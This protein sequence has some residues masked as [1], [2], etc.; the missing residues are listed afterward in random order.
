MPAAGKSSARKPTPAQKPSGAAAAKA[1]GAGV[2]A[3]AAAKGTSGAA[4]T[5]AGAA[6]AAG[7]AAGDGSSL[8]FKDLV[9]QLQAVQASVLALPAVVLKDPAV[10]SA[11]ASLQAFSS[12]LQRAE[13]Q[14]VKSIESVPVVKQLQS[15]LAVLAK[16]LEPYKQAAAA[17]LN[18]ANLVKQLPAP[19]QTVEKEVEKLAA[20]VSELIHIISHDGDKDLFNGYPF[21]K[22]ALALWFASVFAYSS[23]AYKDD[24]TPYRAG[25]YDPKAAERFYAKRWALKWARSAQLISVL[26][27]WSIGV[28]RDKYEY[29]GIGGK[30]NKWEENMPMRAKQILNICTRLGTTAI[31]IG[32][33]LS[34]R[35]D[36]LP[37][38]YVKELSEL[39]DRV[40]PFPTQ[41]A[42]AIIEEEL[43]ASG[44]GSIKSVFRKISQDPVAAASIGQVFKAEL[45]DGTEV[46]VKVQRPGVIQDIALDL[47]I[48]RLVAPLYK[49][50]FK[51]NSD[52]VGLVDEWGRGFVDELDYQREAVNGKRF[53]AAMQARGLD[54]VTTSEVVDDL[55]SD[56]I[57]VTKWVDG[58]RLSKSTEDDVGRLCGVALNAY[59]T[60]L[61]DTGLLHCDPHPGNLLRTP[62]GKLCI[63]D[64]GMCIEVEKDL[65]YGLIEYISHLMS[66]DY[67][68]I[69]G[70]LI[71]L[72][73]VPPGQ[74]AMIQRAG[75]VEALASILKQLAQGG[76]PKKVQERFIKQIK[77]E[78]GDIPREELREKM[79]AR[80]EELNRQGELEQQQRVG[81][82]DVASKMEEMQ[83]DEQNYFQIPPW[84]AYIL[85]TFSVLEGIGLNQDED[86][87]IAQE[88]YPYLARRL[89]TDNSPRAQE[90]LRQMLY[91]SGGTGQL[92]VARLEELASGFQSYTAGT[93]SV[94]RTQGL[95]KAATQAA[96]LVL[97]PEGN[98][99]Q[100]VLLEEI[101]ALVDASGRAALGRATANPVGQIAMEALRQ[102]RNFAQQL[103]APL[104][105]AFLPAELAIDTLELLKPEQEDT[106]AL[107]VA[108]KLWELVQRGG[109]TEV[110]DLAS[111]IGLKGSGTDSGPAGAGAGA[112]FGLSQAQLLQQVR[113][114]RDQEEVQQLVSRLREL[115]PGVAATS[116]RFLSI[117]LQRSASRLEE[118]LD[119][120]QQ[121]MSSS[122]VAFTQQVI[123]ALDSLDLALADF[124]Q[125][126]LKS[127][128][129]AKDK[130]AAAAMGEH[131][132]ETASLQ[133]SQATTATSSAA[134]GGVSANGALMWSKEAQ[135]EL[136]RAP[137]F[138]KGPA[139]EGAEKFAREQGAT[140]VTLEHVSLSKGN[141]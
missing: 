12:S 62:D 108:N 85:R 117:L 38:P 125:D 10:K 140:E 98:F 76:G 109:K 72:G 66:E 107:E 14:A 19:L 137:F 113:L 50:V 71:R 74:E 6:G 39:Q 22:D 80:F 7:A 1:A 11:L 120:H 124:Q 59:L 131:A 129:E 119:L 20:G 138:V 111:D 26:G 31:K 70:D 123:S 104:R 56:R 29:G 41:T 18:V 57:L 21:N 13:V 130:K 28:L 54:T 37:A 96:E 9:Q 42:K 90:A 34:I 24:A 132:A 122:T 100:Q 65:Q 5:A 139:K 68:A 88:C 78:F 35:G 89:F 15:E 135:A 32:Q 53:L 67:Q 101:A 92:N 3:T 45:N 4:A 141:R 64:F 40:K 128:L 99:I 97:S 105:L 17:N 103:P 16:A 69:P 116:A 136:D 55:S 121:T 51:L 8:T 60:M 58:E 2:A 79:V 30:G 61:L 48:V 112:G 49:K 115:Q 23:V 82:A 133:L 118:S 95:D 127:E 52:L 81:V 83:E 47:Y 106:D 110:D 36:I 25:G 114:P 27:G 84:M 134:R 93:Q 126:I 86:Y 94:D 87:S 91:G 77:D 44:A 75:V 63:L 43:A 73:F 102:Q 33:A 46:A